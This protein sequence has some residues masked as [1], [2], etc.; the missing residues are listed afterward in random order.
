[1]IILR[2]ESIVLSTGWIATCRAKM[3]SK[4]KTSRDWELTDVQTFESDREGD[5]TSIQL[6]VPCWSA[7][8]DRCVHML[9]PAFKPFCFS[10]IQM[11]YI[12]TQL[13]HVIKCVWT[14]TQAIW[15][16]AR[17]SSAWAIKKEIWRSYWMLSFKVTTVHAATKTTIR[18]DLHLEI[19]F[20]AVFQKSY[21][22]VRVPT[23]HQIQRWTLFWKHWQR[24]TVFSLK[25]LCKW[26]WR[27]NCRWLSSLS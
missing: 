10:W 14:W 19:L 7:V 23:I 3:L 15:I 1:M 20:W 8:V 2:V 13:S 12:T 27:Y 17:W 5:P 9:Q 11:S 25:M 21:I 22:R 16:S 6:F 24:K 26:S 18:G 4:G